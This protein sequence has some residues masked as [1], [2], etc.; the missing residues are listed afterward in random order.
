MKKIEEK[1]IKRLKN[2]QRLLLKFDVQAYAF[3]PGVRGYVIGHG[4]DVIHFDGVTWKYMEPLLKELVKLRG[5]QQKGV[6]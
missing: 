2:I 3:D 6:L 4:T 5:K 1:E